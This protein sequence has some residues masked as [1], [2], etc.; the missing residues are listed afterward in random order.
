MYDET[1]NPHN[2]VNQM[3]FLTKTDISNLQSYNIIIAL[4]CYI[5]II[6]FLYV[7]RTNRTND[8]NENFLD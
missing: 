3:D 1:L 5:L 2:F 6:M 7:L 8:D 4:I